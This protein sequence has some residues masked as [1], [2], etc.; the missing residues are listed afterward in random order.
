MKLT[1][2]FR[3]FEDCAKKIKDSL[4][5]S[6]QE[7][8]DCAIGRRQTSIQIS[9]YP[10]LQRVSPHLVQTHRETGFMQ[11]SITQKLVTAA[12]LVKE[13]SDLYI[14]RRFNLMSPS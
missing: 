3:N 9:R 13:F 2:A 7:A 14:S 6:Q 11:Q 10:I 12:K 5:M 4:R 8:Q 1:V